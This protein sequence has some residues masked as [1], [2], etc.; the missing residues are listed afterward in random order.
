MSSEGPTAGFYGKLPALGDFVG[1]RLPRDF[2]TPWD[3]WLQ[4]SVAAS[5]NQLGDAWLDT[6]LTSPLWR[7]ALSAGVCGETA[8]AGVMM[9]SVDRVGRYFPLALAVVLPEPVSLPRVAGETGWFTAAEALLLSTLDEETGFDLDAFDARVAELGVPPASADARAAADVAEGVPMRMALPGEAE[10]GSCWPAFADLLAR[11]HL[12]A[13]S[14]WWTAGSDQVE[15]SLLACRGLPAPESFAG[16]LDGVWGDE[17]VAAGP[18]P[19]AASPA[20]GAPLIFDAGF[21]EDP[22]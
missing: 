13:Y 11:R 10:L 18:S 1:R 12:G 4:L 21:P 7:F 3:D 9:P 15:P 2:V 17:G 20:D 19:P 5:R 6:Y 16:M 14:L 22:V 8:C